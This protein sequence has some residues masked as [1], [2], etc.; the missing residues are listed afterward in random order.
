MWI[1]TAFA[2]NVVSSARD[3]SV[4]GLTKLFTD[5]ITAVPF[6]IAAI[7][8]VIVCF[9]LAKFLKSI[10]VYRV[11]SKVGK[12]LNEQLVVLIGRAVYSGVMIMGFLVAFTMVGIDIATFLGFIGLGIGFALKD[13]LANWI[14]GVIILTQKKFM[15]GDTINVDGII[16][17]ITEIDTRVT[18][19]QDFDGT[20]HVIPNAKMMTSTVQ[21]YTRN[22][23]RRIAFQVG[24]HYDTPLEQTVQLTL[25]SVTAHEEVTP[26]PATQVLVQE[27]GD[28]S[29]N[30]EVRFWIESTAAWPA[31]RSRIMQDLKKDYDKAGITIPFPM[32]TLT[33]DSYDR[34]ILQAFNVNGKQRKPFEDQG[35]APAS[36]QPAPNQQ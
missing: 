22:S 13:I 21:N 27:F 5:F 4:G 24:V 25:K 18:Q 16:G 11:T 30:L 34:N 33:L 20:L 8:V 15:I 14:A 1:S 19:I 9:V 3:E 31:I 12:D 23:F 36:P 28:S 29:I 35:S 2:A 6:W 10:V 26:N 7:V 32:R 17:K